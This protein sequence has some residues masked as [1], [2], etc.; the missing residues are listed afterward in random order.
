VTGGDY[1]ARIEAAKNDADELG[2]I[3]DELQSSSDPESRRLRT[4]AIALR[5][6]LRR[7][8]GL[9]RPRRVLAA[10][11]GVQTPSW[12]LALGVPAIDGRP[13]HAYRLADEKFTQLQTDLKAKGPALMFAVDKVLAAKFV[14]WAAEWFRRCYDGT[15][16]RWDA[17]GAPLGLTSTWTNYR[18]LTDIGL[19]YWKIPE[20]RIN[21][22]HHRLAAIAR[23]GGFPL[24]ALEGKG[25]G[26]APRFLER[27]VGMLL[28]QPDASLAVAE[29]IAGSL[30]DLV[31]ETWRSQEIRIVSAELGAEIVR[32]RRLAD[33]A[34]A[35]E[36]SLTSLWLDQHHPSW[37]DELPV[38][39]SSE[40]GRALID[41]LMKITVLRGGAG[42]VGVR[43][44][45]HLKDGTRRELV[46][47]KLTGTLNDIEGRAISR[48]LEENWSRLRLFPS[49]EF[50][51][52]VTGELA[53]ADPDE[54]GTWTSRPSIT[55]SRFD[56]PISV[57]VVAE[58]RGAGARVGEAFCLPGGDAVRSAVG[59]YVAD[60]EEGRDDA[61]LL[62]LVGTG[63]GGYSAEQLF[64]DLPDSW[65]CL[66]HSEQSACELVAGGK[67]RGRALWRVEGAV[68]ATS[69]IGDRFLVRSGQKGAQRDS[70]V[71][72]GAFARDCASVDASLALY[73]GSPRFVLREGVR[74]RSAASSEVIWRTPGTS[75]W[76][77]TTRQP[78]LGLCEFAWRDQQS[79]HIRSRVDAV[80]LSADFSIE[81]RHIG[82]WLELRVSGWPGRMEIDGGVKVSSDC[83]RFAM[84]GSPR[85]STTLRLFCDR[86]ESVEIRIALPH[87]AWIDDWKSGPLTRDARISLSTMNRYVAR[88]DGRC[89]LMADLFDRHRKPVAQ[90]IA[91]WWVDGELPLSTIRDDLAALLRPLG[92]IR[93]TIKLNFN[94]GYDNVWSVGEFDHNLQREG[95]GWRPDSAVIEEDVRIVGRALH[96]PASEREFGYYGSLASGNHRPFELPT[97]HGDW[98]V[99]LRSNERVLSCPQFI[100]G[101][102]MS[103]PPTSTLGKAMAIQERESRLEAICR[104]LDEVFQ[105][106]SSAESREVVKAATGIALSL[107]GLPPS[108]F[109][110]LALICDRPLLGTMMLFHVPIANVD[111]LIRLEEGL[112]T[113]WTLIPAECW[114][115]AARALAEYLFQT[116]PDDPLLVA[117]MVS[118]RRKAIA[119]QVPALAPL[120]GLKADEADLHAAANAFL[121]RSDDR[122]QTMQNPF[123]PLRSEVLPNWAVGEHFWRALD[124]PVAAALSALGFVQLDHAEVRCVKDIS[125]RH[126]RWFR[127]AFAATLKEMQ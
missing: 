72:L 102:D 21:G 99:Y 7:A 69:E 49:G 109:D 33:A 100:R 110:I 114:E 75:A 64:V 121:N 116:A 19:Q 78:E 58:L 51:R 28:A 79:G 76:H 88:A 26:W 125:R 101:A 25:A 94:D 46:E 2:Q 111:A 117:R 92:D 93:A 73:L 23:Q 10:P 85:S 39:V 104:L 127:E 37:R 35:P 45:L 9:L 81:R 5:F 48:N 22:T 70:L 57:P 80:I 86:G 17:L 103:E 55:R 44:L 113:A 60:D 12:I 89:E 32:L 105:E 62:I 112:P 16:Q 36:G 90:G 119:E 77:G 66:P 63:S 14:L 42:A 40:A 53:T 30:M 68:M 41:G 95:R 118:D 43:R 54:D 123:R 38:G 6:N 61:D 4:R 31:P 8:A 126:P 87:Q 50:A 34:G 107:D 13:L 59:V 98:L 27:L 84:R 82:D 83:W 91:S 122:I 124:A 18:K 29:R 96:Q 15:G 24:A 3:A 108:T 11:Q 56:L 65:S 1:A 74:E 120:L 67:Q 52:H 97:L 20:L 106:P 47:L 71:L 115:E